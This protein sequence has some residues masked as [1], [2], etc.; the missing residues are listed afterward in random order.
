MGSCGTLP[1]GVWFTSCPSGFAWDRCWICMGTVNFL[2]NHIKR[3]LQMG[4]CMKHRINEA[5]FP[6]P[7]HPR[8]PVE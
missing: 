6:Q 4:P 5:V 2:G 8:T 3:L 7:S 1:Y